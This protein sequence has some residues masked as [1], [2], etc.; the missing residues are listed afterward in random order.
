MGTDRNL[1]ECWFHW[2]PEANAFATA[3]KALPWRTRM[4]QKMAANRCWTGV[5]LYYRLVYQF[6]YGI[7]YR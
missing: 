7:L 2:F 5:R 3:N 1:Y 6:V 4:L